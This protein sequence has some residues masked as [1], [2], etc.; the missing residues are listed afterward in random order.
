MWRG[1]A[2][3]LGK[4]RGMRIIRSHET[5]LDILKRSGPW[6]A[7][8][9]QGDQFALA[10]SAGLAEDVPQ[11]RLDGIDADAT[12]AGDFGQRC[13]IRQRQAYL[14]FAGREVKLLAQCLAGDVK[15]PRYSGARGWSRRFVANSNKA[16]ELANSILPSALS[17]RTARSGVSSSR[18]L[19]RVPALPR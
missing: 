9:Q 7:A 17:I 10:A 5:G 16:R 13:T 3:S 11:M 8:M 19:Y 6:R 18:S 1:A 15:L 4:R 2:A 12:G 14:A